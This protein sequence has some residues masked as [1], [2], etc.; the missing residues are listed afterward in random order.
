M[1][2]RKGIEGWWRRLAVASAAIAQMPL[3]EGVID[4]SRFQRAGPS[5]A[6]IAPSQELARAGHSCWLRHNPRHEIRLLEASLY[7]LDSIVGR[8]I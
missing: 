7:P 1:V 6:W 2:L 3:D 4:K 5:R 8:A